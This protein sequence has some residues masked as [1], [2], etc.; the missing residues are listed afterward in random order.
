MSEGKPRVGIV[1]VT[2]N[3]WQR[4]RECLE[5]LRK[6]DY[7]PREI[8]VVDNGSYDGTADSIRRDFPEVRL[9]AQSENLGY[10]GGNNAG[11]RSCLDLGVDAVM[12]LNNDA[13]VAPDLLDRM[14]HRLTDRTIV[15]PR[16]WDASSDGEAGA[17]VGTF[18]W[19]W[20]IAIPDPES[21]A[22][23]A[24]AKEV[25]FAAGCCL[26]LPV[27]IF[28]NVGMFDERFFLYYEDLDLL[29]RARTAGYRIVW[30]PRAVVNH[31]PA[32]SSGGSEISPARLYYSTRNRALVMRK[33]RSGM[34][35]AVF[36][37]YYLPSRLI[38]I[39]M[40]LLRGQTRLAG[41]IWLGVFDILRGRWGRTELAFPG[42]E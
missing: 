34:A 4:S 25:G 28:E 2:F 29:E 15:T 21:T 41:A 13:V 20:G 10:T 38:R 14:V 30:E 36:L 32:S 23:D 37:A 7:E 12:I 27:S 3:Q 22:P 18:D 8:V 31:H 1:V 19:T 42:R 24:E 5:S 33:H 26:L 17:L 40:F 11:I 35:N 16:V 39:L 6:L 9:L